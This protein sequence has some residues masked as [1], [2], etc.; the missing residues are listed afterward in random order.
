MQ[1]GLAAPCV[2]LGRSLDTAA[3]A[4]EAS[5]RGLALGRDS[6]NR[7]AE[8]SHWQSR[9]EMNT[10]GQERRER[11]G[12]GGRAGGRWQCCSRGA[13]GSAASQPSRGV[14]PHWGPDALLNVCSSPC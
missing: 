11:G 5:S 3:G 8:L 10:W 7:M 14:S 4:L 6:G 12:G 1:H 13:A 9:N 2:A